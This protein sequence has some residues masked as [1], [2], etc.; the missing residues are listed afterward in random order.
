MGSSGPSRGSAFGA[1]RQPSSWRPGPSPPNHRHRSWNARGNCSQSDRGEAPL[2]LVDR[3]E[4]RG[5]AR[6]EQEEAKQ[7]SEEPKRSPSRNSPGRLH[8]RAFLQHQLLVKIRRTV[9]IVARRPGAPCDVNG[10]YGISG[11]R[12]FSSRDSCSSDAERT[13]TTWVSR[14]V[15]LLAQPARPPHLPCSAYQKARSIEVGTPR[16]P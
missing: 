13:F 10:G 8:T 2:R 1:R 9:R 4:R 12:W 6:R 14:R 5:S 15:A 16:K 3:V 11:D 7:D